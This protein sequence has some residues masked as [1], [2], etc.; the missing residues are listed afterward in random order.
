V[1]EEL[2]AT[3]EALRGDPAAAVELYDQLLAARLLALVQDPHAPLAS[4]LFLTYDTPDGV[5]ELPLFTSPAATLLADLQEQSGAAA[6]EFEGPV[7][8]RRLLDVIDTGHCEAA[9]DPGEAR[10][11]RINR[12]AALGM[13]SSAGGDLGSAV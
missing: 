11:V 3:L 9:V 10:G 12:E 2:V 5:R 13:V 7:L 1:N 6:V 8:W 4:M